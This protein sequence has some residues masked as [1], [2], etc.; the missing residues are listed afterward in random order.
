MNANTDLKSHLANLSSALSSFIGIL[1]PSLAGHVEKHL[2]GGGNGAR[3][4]G[5]E[6][7]ELL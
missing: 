5:A 2:L 4:A 7:D 3:F 6:A 1:L